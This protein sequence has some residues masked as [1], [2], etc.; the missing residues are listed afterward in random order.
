MFDFLNKLEIAV[1][2]ILNSK[3]VIF[4]PAHLASFAHNFVS[5]MQNFYFSEYLGMQKKLQT[6][7]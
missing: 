2:D 6:C 4:L 5:G 7:H 1:V 3:S